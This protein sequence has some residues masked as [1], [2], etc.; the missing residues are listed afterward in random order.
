MWYHL[1]AWNQ[2]LSKCPTCSDGNSI[3]QKQFHVNCHEYPVVGLF[4]ASFQWVLHFH[5][6]YYKEKNKKPYLYLNQPLIFLYVQKGFQSKTISRWSFFIAVLETKR[7]NR[8]IRTS[9]RIITGRKAL[10]G[11]VFNFFRKKYFF[12]LNFVYNWTN[13]LVTNL[14]L[15]HT[16][17]YQLQVD[18][19]LHHCS[20]LNLQ[21]YL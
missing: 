14:S 3:T 20:G 7:E 11:I 2:A 4:S 16:D 9:V 6:R 18:S 1:R 10:P 8:A 21:L 17:V 12:T 5:F 13:I 19:S 15:L